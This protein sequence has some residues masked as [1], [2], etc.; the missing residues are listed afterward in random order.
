MSGDEGA[1]QQPTVT[2]V[3]ATAP[4]LQIPFPGMFPVH[5]VQQVQVVRQGQFPPPDE[6]ERYEAVM[7]GTFDRIMSMAEKQQDAAI[8]AANRGMELQARDVRRGHWL[9]AGTTIGA[10][11][12][13]GVVVAIHGPAVVAVA[14]VGV[15]V[16][17][18]A[19]ALVDSVTATRQ[20]KTQQLALEQ[21]SQE[22]DRAD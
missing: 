20:A 12:A 11:I 6:I 5:Q 21:V 2:R 15:P 8:A 1:A 3:E 4:E 13:A 22:E 7:P 14:L 16:M 18:V 19:K 9:G 10:M 17:S